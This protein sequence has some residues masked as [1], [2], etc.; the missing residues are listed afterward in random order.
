MH[1]QLKLEQDQI[2]PFILADPSVLQKSVSSLEKRIQFLEK[3]LKKE[4][5]EIVTCP[6][7]LGYDL[8]SII[9]QRS[10]FLRSNGIDPST[11]ALNKMFD[12]TD[13]DFVQLVPKKKRKGYDSFKE[14]FKQQ[15]QTT[16]EHKDDEPDEEILEQT[17][18]EEQSLVPMEEVREAERRF[19]R[20]FK[21]QS[22]L[23]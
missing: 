19:A 5:K 23:E 4:P 9:Q 18:I 12:S 7:Y 20:N 6:Q 22:I 8:V 3:D 14:S 15:K 1:S 21:Y 16:E 13:A 11:I 17:F 2:A 10:E